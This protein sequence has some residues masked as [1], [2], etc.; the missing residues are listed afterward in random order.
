MRAF[1]YYL[2]LLS[3]VLVAGCVFAAFL[4]RSED[5]VMLLALSM[6][7]VIDLLGSFQFAVRIS[8]DLESYMTSINRCL[9]YTHIDQEAALFRNN[10]KQL[11]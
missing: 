3:L 1:G 4:V 9:D 10:Q 11:R 6:Q 5:N 8:S 7:L 2:D